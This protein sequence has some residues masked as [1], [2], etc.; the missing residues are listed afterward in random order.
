MLSSLLLCLIGFIIL[1][2][3]ADKL[4]EGASNLALNLGISKTVVGLTIVA[5]GTSLPEMVVSVNASLKGNPALSLGNVVGSNIMNAA[6]ILG[7][8]ALIQ[9]ILCGK[10]MVRREVPIMIVTATL[11]WYMAQT[12]ATITPAEGIILFILF[13]AYTGL[14]YYWSRNE[15]QI[16]N[17]MASKLDEVAGEDGDSSEKVTTRTNIMYLIGGMIGLVV[18]SETLVRGAVFIAHAYGVSD[19]VIGLTL[20]AIGT[21]LPELATSI[22]AARKGQ[23]EIALGN[24]VGSNIFNVLGIV[25]CASVVS[26][27]NPDPATRLLTISPEMLGL[28][29]PLMVV[30]SLGVLPIMSTGMRI[31]RLEGAFLV[32]VYVAY[33]LMLFQTTAPA[34]MA[35]LPDPIPN[36]TQ[37]ANG[38]NA[39]QPA[40]ITSNSAASMPEV[41]PVTPEIA[42]QSAAPTNNENTPVI[43]TEPMPTSWSMTPASASE[44]VAVASA[45]A[46]VAASESEATEPELETIIMPEADPQT[47]VASPSAN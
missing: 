39:S 24:V 1:S 14:S 32:A 7:V 15:T 20:I 31:I 18:G 6:L 33:T 28:H 3:A 34:P 5:A 16:A 45:T 42:T 19:E 35:T 43:A 22:T 37:P 26:F 25:G 17:E 11:L 29:I 47:P 41:L 4:V 30:V 36:I 10:Q 2:Y 44:Q 8:A 9:P 46:A 27:F 12:D 13:F 23:S 21:S 38:N 40:A